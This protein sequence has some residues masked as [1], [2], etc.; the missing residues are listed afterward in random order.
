M[1]ALINAICN[2][3][4]KN[5]LFKRAPNFW[6]MRTQSFFY[7]RGGQLLKTAPLNPQLP[8]GSYK[9]VFTVMIVVLDGPAAVHH[10]HSARSIR[11][12]SFPK[13]FLLKAVQ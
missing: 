3:N 4:I 9:R 6:Q 10:S 5:Q 2:R 7:C 12:C 13:C 11:N 1:G 8:L